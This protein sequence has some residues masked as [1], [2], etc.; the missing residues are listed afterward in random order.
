VRGLK[1]QKAHE[2]YRYAETFRP[3]LRNGFT[4]YGA[5]S[6]VSGLLATVAAEYPRQLEPSIAGSGP[7]AFADRRPHPSSDDAA[8]VHCIPPD[9]RD[10]R[11]T[12]LRSRRDERSKSYISEKRNL[13]ILREGPDWPNQLEVACEN[14]FLAHTIYGLLGS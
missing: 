7:H 13:N 3:S 5:L 9:V 2:Q 14:R 10:D 11:E 12:P 1:A 6:S 8:C 4:A